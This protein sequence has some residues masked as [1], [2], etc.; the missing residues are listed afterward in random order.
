[1]GKNKILFILKRKNNYDVIKDSNIGMSTGLYNSASFMNDMLN[2]AGIESHISVVI[3]NNCIDREVTKHKPTHVIIEALWV[4]P[5]K[6]YVL[7][8]LHPKVKWIIRLH[9]EIP[10]LANEG[11]ALDWLGDYVFFENV[12][13][14]TNAP[15]ATK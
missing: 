3:D 13:I 8:K 7:C 5:S 14:G 15:R 11:M 6:F 2:N 10:F 9:S 1:M 12:Y 4:V